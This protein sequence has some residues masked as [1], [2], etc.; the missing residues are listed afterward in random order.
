MAKTETLT[1][2]K[3]SKMKE[4]IQKI[5]GKLVGLEIPDDIGF[6]AV[7][8]VDESAYK[9]LKSDPL[10]QDQKRESILKIYQRLVQTLGQAY[11]EASDAIQASPMSASETI[12]ELSK[13]RQEEMNKALQEAHQEV[14]K[15]WAALVKSK[16]DYA[17]YK[18]N[19]VIKLV[20][21]SAALAGAVAS[22][23]LA[24]ATFGGTA[25]VSVLALLKA[26]AQL[27]RDIL[28][29]NKAVEAAVGDLK[30]SLTKLA[31]DLVRGAPKDKKLSSARLLAK[32]IL[33][34]LEDDV[35]GTNLL[36]SFLGNLQTTKKQAKLARQKVNGASVKAHKLAQNLSKLLDKQDKLAALIKSLPADTASTKDRKRLESLRQKLA[37]TE[38]LVNA[39]VMT[40]PEQLERFKGLDD[41]LNT[42]LLYYK[43]IKAQTRDLQKVSGTIEKLLL[44]K[45]L[46]LTAIDATSLAAAASE[47]GKAVAQAAAE[48]LVDAG[49]EKLIQLA[50]DKYYGGVVGEIAKGDAEIE[51]HDEKE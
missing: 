43:Q 36:G 47:M 5:S 48:K 31:E 15:V 1:L 22:V 19:V 11:K 26:S 42:L 21:D 38:P 37:K 35:L 45:D 33:G 32:D 29:A 50:V 13:K 18:S 24:A 25:A 16:K 30:A 27:A 12:V 34:L 17:T 44:L 14:V 7:F 3:S 10:L 20:M 4:D 40:I 23:G 2:F 9:V 39:L 51:K 6:A 46:A 49:T 28:D 41:R 8:E